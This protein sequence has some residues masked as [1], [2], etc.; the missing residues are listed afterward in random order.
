MNKDTFYTLL[1]IPAHAT[2][3][4]IDAAYQQQRDRYSAERVVA[5]GDE[6][7]AIAEA[8]NA[9][10]E[11]AYAVLADAERRRAYDAG[12]GVAATPEASAL[13]A[14]SQ[15]QP[16]RS[17]S[18]REL[19]MAAGGALAGLL[20]IAFVWGLAGRSAG[21]ALP[22]A[23]QTNRPAPDF[24]LAGIDG[25]TVRLSDYRGKVVLLNFWYTGCE[26]CREETPALEAAYKKLAPQG[27][28]IIGMNVRAN[29]RQ[30]ADGDADIR[31]FIAA[32]GV[33]YPIALDTDSQSGRDYQVYV[34]PTSLMIDREGKIR[35]LLFSATTTEA[36]EALFTK[37]QQ[38]TSAGR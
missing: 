37:L 30:G 27:F 13:D 2:S 16:K 12:I 29:E 36:V 31:N 8:R 26:P 32:H 11:R 1:D 20:V 34:L 9:E 15:A 19:L 18:R 3:A 17:L 7:R 21:A 10:L 33:S 28:E 4:E 38:E 14:R 25:K 6:F 22:P 5:L 24:S 35:Y 23:A